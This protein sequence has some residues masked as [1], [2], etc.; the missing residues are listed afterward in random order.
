MTVVV[1]SMDGVVSVLSATTKVDVLGTNVDTGIS[2]DVDRRTC[3]VSIG[4]DDDELS[5]TE[6]STVVDSKIVVVIVVELEIFS[7][8]TVV[9]TGI[10]NVVGASIGIGVVE[11][12]CKWDGSTAT[13]GIAC[14]W[15]KIGPGTRTWT[16]AEGDCSIDFGNS[17]IS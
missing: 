2:V 16:I 9:V 14:G 7:A 10:G 5:K 17:G 3:T 13:I 6:T 1:T 11:N 8:A 12:V 4:F 15:S